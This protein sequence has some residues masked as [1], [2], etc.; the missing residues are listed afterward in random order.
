MEFLIVYQHI[1]HIF[2]HGFQRNYLYVVSP[3]YPQGFLEEL[4]KS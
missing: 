3:I 4:P 2:L 1:F